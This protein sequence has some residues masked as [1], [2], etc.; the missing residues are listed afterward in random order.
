MRGLLAVLCEA[1]HFAASLH[2]S[3]HL[4]PAVHLLRD[5]GQRGHIFARVVA[6]VEAGSH[7]R[8]FVLAIQVHH[9]FVFAREALTIGIRLF[10]CVHALII[11]VVAPIRV[12]LVEC[13]CQELLIALRVQLRLLC[14]LLNERSLSV[15]SVCRGDGLA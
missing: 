5:L 11:I 15:L 2:A 6:E 7:V 14:V 3:G 9:A 13:L 12:N 1:L 8:I 10:I 4:H